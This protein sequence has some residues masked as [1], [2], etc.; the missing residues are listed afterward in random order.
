MR[1]QTNEVTTIPLHVFRTGK[2]KI[3]IIFYIAQVKFIIFNDLK[4][5]KDKIHDKTTY[6]GAK[7]IKFP[8]IS[9]ACLD[10][11][12]SLSNL[13]NSLTFPWP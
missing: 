9:L 1:M 6:F 10:S 7:M 8:D 3:N 4:K 13:Q 2:L 5:K 11:K 12:I